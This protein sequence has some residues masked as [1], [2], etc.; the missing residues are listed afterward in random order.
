MGLSGDA[1]QRAL[2]A[3]H[4]GWGPG[5]EVAGREWVGAVLGA[6]LDDPYA[7]I[8]C[9]AERSLRAVSPGLVPSG[10]DY[11]IP[12]DGRSAVMGGV[13]SAWSRTMGD[14]AHGGGG[15]ASGILVRAGDEEGT[16]GRLRELI[17]RRD[18]RVV[19]LRE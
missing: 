3:W 13:I 16:M 14:R 4:L 1:G 10:Y 15:G 9:V 7:A 2:V 6:M 17:S 12:V 19:R 8:R 11:T 5:L 18:E